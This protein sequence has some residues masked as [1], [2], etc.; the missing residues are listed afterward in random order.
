MPLSSMQKLGQTV[1]QTHKSILRESGFCTQKKLINRV[2]KLCTCSVL[3]KN[4]V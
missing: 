2:N 4:V 3:K 1:I